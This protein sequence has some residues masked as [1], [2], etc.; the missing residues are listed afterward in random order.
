MYVALSRATGLRGLKIKGN[1]EGLS[2]GRG[3]NADV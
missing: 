3:G 2:V 1:P